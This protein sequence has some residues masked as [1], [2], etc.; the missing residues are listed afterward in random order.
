MQPSRKVLGGDALEN[1]HGDAPFQ[2][3]YQGPV[4]PPF[5]EGEFVYPQD[6]RENRRELLQSLQ[7]DQRVWTGDE[8]QKPGPRAAISALLQWANSNRESLVRWV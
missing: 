2:V 1:V 4:G 3:Y 7:P 5:P 8:P 6:S